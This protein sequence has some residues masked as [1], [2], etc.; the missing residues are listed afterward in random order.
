MRTFCLVVT[1]NS[2]ILVVTSAAES[3]VCVG[4]NV[5]VSFDISWYVLVLNG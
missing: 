3:S 2:S 5:V 1:G 4:V